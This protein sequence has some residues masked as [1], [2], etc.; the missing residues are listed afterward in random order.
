[1]EK[2]FINPSDQELP[3]DYPELFE[4]LRPTNGVQLLQ[5]PTLDKLSNVAYLWL[6]KKKR[7]P[8]MNMINSSL[9]TATILIL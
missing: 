5:K 1:M 2:T 6:N 4:K 7:F 8:L 9:V 3:V